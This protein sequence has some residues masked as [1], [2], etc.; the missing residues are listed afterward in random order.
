MAYYEN[1]STSLPLA[2]AQY[3]VRNALRPFLRKKDASFVVIMVAPSSQPMWFYEHAAAHILLPGTEALREDGSETVIITSTSEIASKSARAIASKFRNARRSVILCGNADEITADLRL[4]ADAVAFIPTP[5]AAHYLMAAKLVG[6]P[7]VTKGAA[8]FLSSQS[9]EDVQLAFRSGQPFSRSLQRLKLKARGA[10][11]ATPPRPLSTGEVRLE[12]LAGY[13]EAKEWGLQ[14][15][16]DLT[17]WQRGEIRWEDLDRGA[18]LLGPPGCGKTTYAGA[19]AKSCGAELVITS[20]A[21]WQAKGHLG[22][23]I[24]AMRESF[25]QAKAKQ[26]AIL[27]IDEFDSVGDREAHPNSDH[28]DYKRQAINALLECLDPSEGREGVVVIG[29]AN[30]AS[31]VDRA[32]LRPG[33]LERVIPIDLPDAEAR[34]KIFRR[35]AGDIDGIEGCE[36]FFVA[37]NGWSG[38]ELEKL[39]RDARRLSRQRGAA[40]TLQDVIDALP[41]LLR[42]SESERLRLAVHEAGHALVGALLRPGQLDHVYVM[43]QVP[44]GGP[45]LPLGEA[46]FEDSSFRLPTERDFS[47]RIAILLGG[48]AA[49]RVVL[50]DHSAGAGGQRE[51]DLALATDFATMMEC[52]YGFG[53]ELIVDLGNGSRP[54]EVLRQGNPS[55]RKAVE[56]RLREALAKAMSLLTSRR[57]ELDTLTRLL[58]EFRIVPGEDV[59][60]LVR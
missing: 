60:R 22:D 33:R 12:D 25:G 57:R 29:A 3:G 45:R 49:E 15:A 2:V 41:P 36:Q 16:A 54:L 56:A 44:P 10:V 55:L 28:A 47:D 34:V 19:L 38:A 30:N 48:I 8:E 27:F 50:G 24:K 20:A 11:K 9:F 14:L 21:R 26:P 37:T 4:L 59:E 23:Y 35:H 1:F 52:H 51:S 5:T 18:L 46:I 17:A 53:N 42:L 13:G 39:A 32:L 6:L 58:L 43:D 31:V 40:V 7:R